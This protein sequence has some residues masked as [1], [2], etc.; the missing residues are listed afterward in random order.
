[1]S[2]LDIRETN[3]AVRQLIEKTENPRHRYLLI[4]YDRHRNLEMAGRYEEIFAPDMTVDEPV[5]H[6]RTYEIDGM[7]RRW[8]S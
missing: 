1:M 2:T 5:Y 7:L 6:F 3:R 4:A 8:R